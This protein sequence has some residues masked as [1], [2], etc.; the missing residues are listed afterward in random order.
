MVEEDKLTDK[1]LKVMDDIEKY[2]KEE[3]PKNNYSLYLTEENIEFLKK[4]LKVPLSQ[5]VDDLIKVMIFSIKDI[6]KRKKEEKEK[7][8]EQQTQ[9]QQEEKKESDKNGG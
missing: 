8:A 6:E 5:A 2:L 3:K 7:Q 4:K 9:P 1:K